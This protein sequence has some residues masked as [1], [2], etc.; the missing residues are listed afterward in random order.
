MKKLKIV[1]EDKDLLVVNKEAKLLTISTNK[2]K[3]RTLYNEASNYVKKQNPKNKIFI[4]HRLDRE[5][6]GIIIFA[7][8][9]TIKHQLQNNWD[10]IVQEREYVA[11]VEGKLV[12][13]G[14]IKNYLFETKTLKVISTNDA[15]KGKLA[16]TNY[17]SLKST[18]AYS[19]I[20][21]SILTGRKN[22]IR[23]HMNDIN[24]PII[25]DKK[26]NAKANPLG[27][28]GLHATKLTLIHPKTKKI[29]NFNC[30]LPKEFA[31]LFK[32]N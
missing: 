27:R 3:E 15:K 13:K 8:N 10:K 1:Y 29:M 26:Y 28:L 22:Q 5:T 25:G 24:H 18:K 30:E 7:K 17:K 6:S 21:I 32:E 9:E 11:I 19:M 16:I 14:T 31:K 2:E 4:V 12:G 20:K 23:V